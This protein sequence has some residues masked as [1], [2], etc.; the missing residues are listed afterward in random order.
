[1]VYKLFVKELNG[2]YKSRYLFTPQAMLTRTCDGWD[3][4]AWHTVVNC[5]SEH[6]KGYNKAELTLTDVSLVVVK[7][8]DFATVWSGRISQLFHQMIEKWGARATL[9]PLPMTIENF[10]EATADEY[11]FAPNLEPHP[12]KNRM[13]HGIT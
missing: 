9:G 3:R 1:V 12:L 11:D 4:L 2:I 5:S 10:F 8:A 6:G 13:S 7:I